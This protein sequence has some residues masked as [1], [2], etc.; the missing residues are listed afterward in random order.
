VIGSGSLGASGE[1][2]GVGLAVPANGPVQSGLR[3]AMLG[4]QRL[5]DVVVVG[6]VAVEDVAD[7]AGEGDFVAVGAGG[8]VPGPQQVPD[9]AVLV[10]L[11]FVV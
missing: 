5:E 10:I 4:G 9:Q 1:A 3:S 11:E 2:V 8:H 7:P 6:G